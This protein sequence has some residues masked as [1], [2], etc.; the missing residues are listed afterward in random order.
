MTLDAIEAKYREYRSRR[1]PKRGM[2]M[3]GNCY[4]FALILRDWLSFQGISSRIVYDMIDGHFLNVFEM[5]M[6]A[7]SEVSFTVL[8]D[9]EGMHALYPGYA[10][11]LGDVFYG[12]GKHCLVP[13]PSYSETDSLHYVRIVRDC[14]L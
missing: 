10:A 6:K 9:W 11:R 3:E 1:F 2:W 7:S 5:P 13:W 12:N 14:C 4:P 8:A